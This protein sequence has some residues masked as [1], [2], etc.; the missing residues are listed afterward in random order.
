VGVTAVVGVSGTGVGDGVGLAEAENSRTSCGALLPLSR[1]ARFIYFASLVTI[2]RLNTLRGRA[3]VVTSTL[4]HWPLEKG[5]DRAIT[6]VP[7]AGAF[8]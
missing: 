3:S 4:V 5:P 1:L 2:A 7:T 6:V 8:W